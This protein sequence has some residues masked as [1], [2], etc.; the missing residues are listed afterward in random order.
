MI[1]PPSPRLL[2]LGIDPGVIAYNC[3]KHGM[4]CPKLAMPM[5]LGAGSR[6]ADLGGYK[7]NGTKSSTINQ[8]STGLQF[9]GSAYITANVSVSA[10]ITVSIMCKTSGITDTIMQGRSGITERWWWYLDGPGFKIY[11]GTGWSTE[12]SAVNDDTWHMLSFVA[13]GTNIKAFIDGRE[14]KSNVLASP[15][16]ID[17]IQIGA[18][19]GAL[20]YSG[21]LANAIIHDE[22][23][24]AV[25]IKLLYH[26]SF[27]MYQ[28]T[29][30]LY[31]YVAG[32]PPA[33][34][35]MN[36]FQYLNLGSDLFNGALI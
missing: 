18:R 26:N 20:I 23:L 3:Q 13:D 11:N 35:I 1:Y 8:L 9:D 15:G 30:E 19:G 32:A 36:Q 5:L 2:T 25:Q 31:G 34:A 14:D 4:P 29:E 12:T 22:A 24:S 21:I 7:S 28:M 17:N 10:N 6:V 27:F 16:A 33:G